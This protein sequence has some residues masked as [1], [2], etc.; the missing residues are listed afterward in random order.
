MCSNKKTLSCIFDGNNCSVLS[1]TYR[2]SASKSKRP[3]PLP[4]QKKQQHPISSTLTNQI[5]I[6]FKNKNRLLTGIDEN[7]TFTDLKLALIITFYKKRLSRSNQP[8]DVQLKKFQKNFDYL[9][10][11]ASEDYVITESINDVVKMIDSDQR[12][13]NV[14]K[15]IHR[16]SSLSHQDCKVTHAMRLKRSILRLSPEKGTPSKKKRSKSASKRRSTLTGRPES[17]VP[18]QDEFFLDN[19]EN[20]VIEVPPTYESMSSSNDIDEQLKFFDIIIKQRK[21]YI[22]LLEKY[23]SLSDELEADMLAKQESQVPHF[24]L[25]EPKAKKSAKLSLESS[26]S[27]STD[28]GF[29]SVHDD[30]VSASE[31]LTD[32]FS[33]WCISKSVPEQNKMYF[34]KISNFETYV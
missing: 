26:E 5:H 25:I 7:T 24:T 31:S 21:E 12:V 15:R 22:I 33:E 32:K 29:G 4:Q 11:V 28:T 18:I 20:D 27:S 34:Q 8:E 6:Q 2:R 19:D 1:D 30:T 16:G 23:L 14:L 9:K 3:E 13:R 10:K 17:E